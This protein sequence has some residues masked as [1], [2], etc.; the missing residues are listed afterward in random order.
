[1]TPSTGPNGAEPD[2]VPRSPGAS[3][4][5]APTDRPTDPPDPLDRAVR[6][7]ERHVARGGWD[8]PVRVFALIR[9]AQALR[10]DPSLAEQLPPDLVAS[11]QADPDHITSV[12]QEGLPQADTI[13]EL[14]AQITWGPSVDGAALVCERLVV[15]PEAEADLPDDPDEALA[16]LMEHPQR[17]DVRLAVGVMRDG[18]TRCAIRTRAHDEDHAVGTG[19][20]LAP[21]VA[22]ALRATLEP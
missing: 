1:M 10:R 4:A 18:A 11:A 19:A 2:G 7:L 17:Q 20:D 3:A 22:A 5:D 6:E 9:T 8:A 16:R 12:E 15:P 21:G 13:E 14:L